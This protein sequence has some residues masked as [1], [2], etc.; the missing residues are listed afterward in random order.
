MKPCAFAAALAALCLPAST[1]LAYGGQVLSELPCP[2][3]EP[4]GLAVDGDFLW[5]SDMTAPAVVKVRA[6]DGAIVSRF[7]VPGFAPT[8]LAVRDGTLLIADRNLDYITRR[9]TSTELSPSTIPFYEQW[10]AGMAW[11]GAHLWVADARNAKIHEID[12]DDGTTIQ[13]FEAPAKAPS[14]L[15]FD[16]RYL[17]VADHGK[18][19]LYRVDRRDGA[20]LTILPSPGPYPNALAA[21]D[22]TLWVAD[23]Q[24]RRLSRVALPD[25]TPYV[26]DQPRR[27]HISYSVAYRGKGTGTVSNL[28]SYVAVPREIPGQHILG[29]LKFDPTPSRVIT[30]AWGQQ[31]AVFELGSLPAGKERT[32]RWEGDFA[33]Y[34]LRFHI[35]PERVNRD[36]IPASMKPWLADGK[37][38]DLSSPELAA[39]VDKVTDGKTT[40]YDKA[41]AIYEHI[42]KVI[43]YD[44]S[45]GWDDAAAVLKRGTGSCSEYTFALVAMLRKAGIPARY[46]GAVSERGDQASFDDVFHR[47]A[48]AWLPGYGW[49]PLDANAAHGEPPGERGAYFGGRSNRQLVTTIEGGGTP[50]LDWSYNSYETWDAMGDATLE[51]MPIAR[52][53]PLEAGPPP[54]AASAPSVLAPRLT[55]AEPVSGPPAS[56]DTHTQPRGSDPWFAAVALLLAAALGLAVGRFGARSQEP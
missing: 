19:E 49:V 10:P 45:A 54:A 2:V 44:R 36:P 55:P 21:A 13:S 33:L 12:A 37:K 39:I 16:G 51:T 56:G 29:A 28:V 26:E 47:W 4:M 20:V 14:G 34:R 35:L 3:D 22:G 15:A 48:E 31:I 17:W 18:D 6:A 52:Y 40:T 23:Y 5:I 30:D 25:D 38:Y 41:R 7:E 11:D 27:V 46:V 9:S 42:A 32:V 24:T 43:T 50:Y 8:G 53:R 1:A